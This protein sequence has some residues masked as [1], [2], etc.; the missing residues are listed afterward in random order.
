MKLP[1][2]DTGVLVDRFGLCEDIIKVHP[3][4]YDDLNDVQ[5]TQVESEFGVKILGEFVGHDN[6][7]KKQ[8]QTYLL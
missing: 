6:Y 2:Q 8:P 7:I 1:I 3:S 5:Q 4:N